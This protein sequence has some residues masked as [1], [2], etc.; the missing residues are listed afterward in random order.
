MKIVVQ[1]V[2][3]AQVC[4]ES[5]IV[6]QIGKGLLIFLGIGKEDTEDDADYLAQKVI[7]LRIFQDKEDKMNLSS[8]D[9]A[10]S[11]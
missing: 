1:R 6:G 3:E 10:T 4:V 2:S 7:Q 9:V 8:F 11:R 5:E